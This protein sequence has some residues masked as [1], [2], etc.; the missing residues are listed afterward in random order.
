MINLIKHFS[1]VSLVFSVCISQDHIVKIQI[2]AMK[3]TFII[4]I[5]LYFGSKN[6]LLFNILLSRDDWI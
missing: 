2:Y 4:Q 5:P 6:K 3:L 1:V